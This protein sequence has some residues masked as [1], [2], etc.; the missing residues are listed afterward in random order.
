MC[1]TRFKWN[2]TWWSSTTP[3]NSKPRA[4]GNVRDDGL[5]KGRNKP[6]ADGNVRDDGLL[7]YKSFNE[8]PLPRE[9]AFLHQTWIVLGGFWIVEREAVF[10]AP[11]DLI[12]RAVGGFKE[13]FVIFAVLRIE[14]NPY[15]RA[16]R[17][18]FFFK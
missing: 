16:N 5:R 4:D 10:A 8:R 6:R 3:A 1:L 12:H 14:R 18:L 9:A 11:F 17:N 13:I 7:K 2:R 15:A